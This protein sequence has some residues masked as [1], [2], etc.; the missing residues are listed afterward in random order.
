M[1]RK[2]VEEEA[3]RVAEVDQQKRKEVET[4]QAKIAQ[5]I[6]TRGKLE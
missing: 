2:A 6:E 1:I 3:S 5:D 4:I